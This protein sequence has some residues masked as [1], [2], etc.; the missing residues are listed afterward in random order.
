MIPEGENSEFADEFIANTTAGR[1]I[2]EIYGFNFSANV[3]Q[4]RSQ[5]PRLW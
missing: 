2:F 1:N 4:V 3:E 5:A